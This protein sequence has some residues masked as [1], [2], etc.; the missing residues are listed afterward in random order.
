MARNGQLE[1]HERCGCADGDVAP[2]CG[3]GEDARQYA[4]GGEDEE[5]ETADSPG[6][7]E[8]EHPGTEGQGELAEC[9]R[10]GEPDQEHNDGHD[11]REAKGQRRLT[12]GGAEEVQGRGGEGKDEPGSDEPGGELRVVFHN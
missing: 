11:G 4:I 6:L 2:S 9:R 3:P 5:D 12:R 1:G 8:G 10:R 7:D